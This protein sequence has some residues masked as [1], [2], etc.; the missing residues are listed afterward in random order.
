MEKNLNITDEEWEKLRRSPF[1]MEDFLKALQMFDSIRYIAGASDFSARVYAD[2]QKLMKLAEGVFANGCRD[3]AG[4]LFFEASCLNEQMGNL[5]TWI[6][7][8]RGALDMLE[9]LRPASL[10]APDDPAAE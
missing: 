3:S 7:R 1:D 2:M 10:E 4:E 9:E 5:E 6:S 8:V